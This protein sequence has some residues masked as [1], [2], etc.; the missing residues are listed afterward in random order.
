M[1]QTTTVPTAMTRTTE[2]TAA[3]DRFV[4]INKGRKSIPTPPTSESPAKR[5]LDQQKQQQQQPTGK[6]TQDPQDLLQ[7]VR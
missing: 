5:W 6:Y 2:N 3:R 7:Q 1:A 4:V